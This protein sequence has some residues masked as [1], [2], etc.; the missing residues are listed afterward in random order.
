MNKI[1]NG[2]IEH[3][4]YYNADSN[5][6]IM[7]VIPELE[8]KVVT[9]LATMMDPAEGMCVHVEGDEV[10]S[11]T[12]GKQ[13]KAGVCSQCMPSTTHGLYKFLSGGSFHG[14]GE[15][16]ARKIVD[17]FGADTI[18]VLDDHPEKL[19]EIPRFGKTR[20][21]NLAKQWNENRSVIDVMVFLQKHGITTAYA[22]RIYNRYKEEAVEVITANP[23]VLS[24][25]IDGIGFKTAD[26]IALNMGFEKNSPKRIC[27]AIDYVM[28]NITDSG[29][30]YCFSDPFKK[31]VCALL[32][33]GEEDVQTCIDE[34]VGYGEIVR[35]GIT[36]SDPKVYRCELNIAERINDLVKYGEL[37]PEPSDDELAAVERALGITYDEKQREAIRIAVRNPFSVIT[38]G[39]GTGKTTITKGVIMIFHMRGLD[40]MCAAPTGKAS[41]RMSEATGME[42]STIHRMLGYKAN[43]EV[44]YNPYNPLQTDVV[45]LDEM[46][47]TNVL[48]ANTLFKAISPETKIILIGDV[49]QL[50]CI[51]PGNILSDIIESGKCPC[52]RLQFVFRQGTSSNIT[53]AAYDVNSG[54]VPYTYNTPD[55]DFFYVSRTGDN[56]WTE[57]IVNLVK[58]RL[59]ERYGYDPMDIQVLSPMKDSMAGVNNLNLALQ[60]ALNPDGEKIT[61]GFSRFRVGDKVMQTKNNYVK[62]VFNGE[63][64]IIVHND[65]MEKKIM[66]RFKDRIVEYEYREMEELMLAYAITVHKSQGSEYKVVVMPISKSHYIMLKRNLI[67]TA[68]TRARDLCVL[69]GDQQSFTIGVNKVD[70]ERRNTRLKNLMNDI[71]SGKTIE[72]PEE[73]EREVE[74]TKVEK[75][76]YKLK[77]V[78]K[79]KPPVPTFPEP[80][81]PVPKKDDEVS[82][83][84]GW[85]MD[86][87]EKRRLIREI[88][89]SFF[90]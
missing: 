15:G 71:Y 44:T 3:I 24:S 84:F 14:I 68:V 48:L 39:P 42:C 75:T 5:Y 70:V 82:P 85:G 62:D 49:D 51:G 76:K 89:E 55:S 17:T 6:V 18:E 33:V 79:L 2:T 31:E 8:K 35:D 64:G 41:D 4:T 46:S 37:M 61:F 20:A 56:D 40:V 83:A 45:I 1:F 7:N 72:V 65:E 28:G 23:Y 50:P 16:W 74:R 87:E 77:D 29:S 10:Y 60:E 27:A 52:V 22:N 34:M 54:K 78:V 26:E 21:E 69:V 63:S 81:K 19:L 25:E 57:Y 88:S 9:V 30:T 73:K 12:Y 67:Y 90:N 47:M 11:P 66:V 36:L 80:V 59:P 86:E 43:G 32:G 13:I 58:N 38:G 53:L